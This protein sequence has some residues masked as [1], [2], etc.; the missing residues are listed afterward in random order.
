[1]HVN[2]DSA[3]FILLIDLTLIQLI[4]KYKENHRAKYVGQ[5]SFVRKLSSGRHTHSGP[6]ALHDH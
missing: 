5:T 1:M 4:N 2:V 3:L 6:I